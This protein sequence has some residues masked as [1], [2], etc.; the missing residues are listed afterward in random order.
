MSDSCLKEFWRDVF[1]RYETV[2]VVVVEDARVKVTYLAIMIAI[3][4]FCLWNLGANNGYCEIVPLDSTNYAHNSFWST[5]IWH[6]NNLLRRPQRYCEDYTGPNAINTDFYYDQE[7]HYLDNT[8]IW[9]FRSKDLAYKTANGLAATTSFGMQDIQKG[10][11]YTALLVPFAELFEFQYSISVNLRKYKHQIPKLY[12]QDF[13]GNWLE[14]GNGHSNETV[15]MINGDLKF[16]IKNLLRRANISLDDVNS[17]NKHDFKEHDGEPIYRL[18]GVNIKMLIEVSNYKFKKSHFDET[19]RARITPSIETNPEKVTWS[20]NGWKT[21]AFPFEN[22]PRDQNFSLPN[23]TSEF[24][25]LSSSSNFTVINDFYT[26]DVN[27][28]FAVTGSFCFIS[29]YALMQSIIE[30]AVLFSVAT[31]FV[32]TFFTKILQ[33]FEKAKVTWDSQEHATHLKAKQLLKHAGSDEVKRAIKEQRSVYPIQWVNR[34]D[35]R[36]AG[37]QKAPPINFLGSPGVAEGFVEVD[38]NY[39]HYTAMDADLMSP[40]VQDSPFS[41]KKHIAKAASF[42]SDLDNAWNGIDFDGSP[43]WN[44]PSIE[45]VPQTSSNNSLYVDAKVRL[46]NLRNH[47]HLNNKVGTI[48]ALNIDESR[49]SHAVKLEDGMIVSVRDNLLKLVKETFEMPLKKPHEPPPET[50]K[51]D[52]YDRRRESIPES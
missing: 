23:R 8:C 16:K 15:Y 46:I 32:D 30:L 3:F 29:W 41:Y 52:P 4:L 7:W 9:E 25:G 27:V 10:D 34:E 37:F 44:V 38:D 31:L 33:T 47:P 45:L 36:K 5:K 40:H 22:R 21:V 51:R 24:Y 6:D 39:G 2:K 49:E 43:L 13:N 28:E 20:C 18:T 26:C 11:I 35:T 14:I 12:S 19:L 17:Y 48:V 50:K 42:E 1:H